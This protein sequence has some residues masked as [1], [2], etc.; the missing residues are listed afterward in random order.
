MIIPEG[1]AQISLEF[2][3]VI[4]D[5][6]PFVTFGVQNVLVDGAAEIASSVEVACK[7]LVEN[8]C[9]T[10]TQLIGIHVKKGPNSTGAA[11]SRSVSQAGTVGGTA[12]YSN[13]AYLVEKQTALGGRQG[14]G[15]MFIP[16]VS[17]SI[18]DPGGLLTPANIVLF[19]AELESFLDSLDLASLPM[20]LLHNN[21]LTPTP[22]SGMQV[23]P[24]A[25]TQRRRMR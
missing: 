7:S 8:F 21:A 13:T 24:K 18:V 25:A 4:Y 20:V 1:Y 14:R 10:T 16:G 5:H 12:G 19:D 3:G 22:V 11:A 15:R 6:N 2:S 17:D 9:H 23:D